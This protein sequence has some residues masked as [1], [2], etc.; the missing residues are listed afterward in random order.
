MARNEE[1]GR[2]A[3]YFAVRKESPVHRKVLVRS[4]AS[5]RNYS[6]KYLPCVTAANEGALHA[7][8]REYFKL[9][10]KQAPSTVVGP[11]PKEFRFV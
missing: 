3:V 1:R 9:G 8:R 11:L 2:P 10:T 5:A 7:D 4:I 6:N